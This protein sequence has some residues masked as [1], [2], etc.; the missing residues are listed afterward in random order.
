[1]AAL[2]EAWNV[3][4]GLP[5]PWL[6]IQ[7]GALFMRTE[8]ELILQSCRAVP[9]RLL[10]AGFHFDFPAWPQAA[11]DLAQQWRHRNE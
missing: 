9:G 5:A 7:F 11:E 3:P 8:P 2:R 6:A 1:M 10:D 4:N